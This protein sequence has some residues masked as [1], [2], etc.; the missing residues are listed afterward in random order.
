MINKLVQ[1]DRSDMKLTHRKSATLDSK[2]S[3]FF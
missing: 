1:M 3:S 2:V